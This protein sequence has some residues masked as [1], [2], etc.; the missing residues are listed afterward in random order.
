MIKIINTGTAENIIKR[1]TEDLPLLK[2]LNKF[3]VE[4]RGYVVKMPKPGMPVLACVS[5]G[6]DSIS[7]LAVLMEKFKLKV[8]PFFI[9]REQ[10]NLKYENASVDFF[11]R[12]YKKRYPKLYNDVLKIG[13][14]TPAR[15]YKEMARA[16]KEMN[17]ITADNVCCRNKIAYPARNPIIFLTGM[18]Y[19]YSLQSKIKDYPKTVFAVFSNNNNDELYHSVLTSVRLT[20]M[21]MC[22]IT[23]DYSWQFM[24]I[25]IETEFGNYYDKDIYIKFASSIG[26]PLEK[27]RSC[28]KRTKNHCG[29]C[30]SCLERKKAFKKAGVKDITKYD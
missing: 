1:T 3:F 8:Y 23:N 15:E 5:G 13:V 16:T 10:T 4:K 12:Y 18:E 7:N 6:L 11:N 26:I 27:T 21:L 2:I 17:F 29:K 24:S 19:G 25:P 22:Q 20:N 14:N 9:K 30:N 28:V